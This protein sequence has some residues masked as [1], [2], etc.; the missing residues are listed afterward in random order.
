VNK[1]AIFLCCVLIWLPANTP[2]QH[3]A[4]GNPA[5]LGSPNT[6]L[7][8]LK[9]ASEYSR[10]IPKLRRYGLKV[11][12][13]SERVRQPFFSVSARILNVNNEALQIFEY[14]TQSAMANDA[15]NISKDGMTIGTSKPFWAA[16]PHFFYSQKLIVLY[17][18]SDQ[19]IL[20]A[21]QAALKN[22]YD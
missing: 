3:A 16:P 15:R 19:R 17:V 4:K 10:L 2:G 13:S 7:A 9:R 22:T 11:R 1:I 18:G 8:E 20:T 6:P 21:L 5:T 14:S 12:S